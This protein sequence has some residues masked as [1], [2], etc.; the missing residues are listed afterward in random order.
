MTL[1]LKTLPLAALVLGS[2]LVTIAHAQDKYPSRAITLIVAAPAGGGTDI[3]AR[4]VGNQ[5]EKQLGQPVIVENRPGGGGV[6]AA[7]FVAR[8]KPDGYTVMVTFDGHTIS[9]ASNAKLNYDTIKSFTP[10]TQLTSSAIVMTAKADIPAKDIKSFLEWAKAY[11][12]NLN[13]GVPG[14]TSPGAAAAKAFI[15]QAGLDAE[16]I[17]NQGS[18]KALLGVLGG[19]YQF[20]FTSLAS[21][22]GQVKDGQLR[23]IGITTA[24]P[25]PILPDVAPIATVLPGYNFESWYGLMGPAAMPEPVVARLADETRKAL[26]APAVKEALSKEGSSAVGSTPAEFKAMLEADLK[27]WSEFVKNTK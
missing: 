7:D 23:A 3:V 1:K 25:S 9:G 4:V 19:E 11:K 20:A 12:G 8:E 10:I 27:T 17:N 14:A 18:A 6:V 13:V 16:I 2:A 24:R 21:A 22:V 15:D 5:L 26:A